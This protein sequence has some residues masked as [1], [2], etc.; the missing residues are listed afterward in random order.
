MNAWLKVITAITRPVGI[1]GVHSLY[2]DSAEVGTRFPHDS[3]PS[4]HAQG[5]ATL[6]GYIAYEVNRRNI[7]I[8]VALLVGLISVA[9]L[10]TGVHW[11]LDITAGV[12]LALVI[13]VI[14]H[15]AVKK[16]TKLSYKVKMTLAIGLPIIMMF[17]FTDPEGVKYAGFILGAGVGYL[18]E[19]KYVRMKLAASWLNRIAGYFIGLIGIFVLQEGLKIPFPDHAFFDGLRYAIMGIWGILL[20]P[21]VFVKLKLYPRS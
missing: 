13:I 7:W 20:A 10:Y 1:E 2:V 5:S 8:A 4:G 21:L 3:F 19:T 18:L 15:F 17:L 12:L 11:P 16:I 9:R 14:A 6:W